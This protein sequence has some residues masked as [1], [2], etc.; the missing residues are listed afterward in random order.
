M[1]RRGSLTAIVL[2]TAI[3]WVTAGCGGP[4]SSATT[5]VPGASVGGDAVPVT[6][7]A[8]D[9][10][11]TP[12]TYAVPAGQPLQITFRNADAGVPHNL[13]IKG[14]PGLATEVIKTEIITGVADQQTTVPG[15]VPGQ[16]QFTCSVH[17]T[18]TAVLNV[19]G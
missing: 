13:V 7:T 9:I 8:K 5:A 2:V 16:Y 6:V 12:A 10:A 3:G 4:A 19:G 14:G 15:L 17:P 18:M 11:L 1:P